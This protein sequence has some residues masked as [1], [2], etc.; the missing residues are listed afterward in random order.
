MRSLIRTRTF[1]VY[2]RHLLQ[3]ANRLQSHFPVNT[4]NMSKRKH[5]EDVHSDRKLRAA[6]AWERDNRTVAQLATGSIGIHRVAYPRAS[7]LGLP[8]EIRDLSE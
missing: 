3:E 5:D 8:R 2:T 4:V 1:D 7:L 6:P